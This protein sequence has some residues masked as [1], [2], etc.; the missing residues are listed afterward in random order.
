MTVRLVG[1][2]SRKITAKWNL[3]IEPVNLIAVAWLQI[4]TELTTGRAMKK[5]NSP[6]CFGWFPD[7]S[8]KKFCDN[9][10]KLAFHRQLSGT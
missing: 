1:S 2:N 6:D 8:N 10:C 9:R 4:A 7:R 5:C 3:E